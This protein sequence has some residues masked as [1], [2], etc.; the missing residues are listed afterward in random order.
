MPTWL[1]VVLI[2]LVVVIVVR[3]VTIQRKL[4][5]Q[6]P[7]IEALTQAGPIDIELRM[8]MDYITNN[9]MIEENELQEA[10]QYSA[11]LRDKVKDL[12]QGPVLEGGAIYLRH[13]LRF[14]ELV[15]EFY[16]AAPFNMHQRS[17]ADR[18]HEFMKRQRQ[19]Q[20]RGER[21]V[22]AN[23]TRSFVN[24]LFRGVADVRDV[25]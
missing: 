2:L 18:F 11:V 5:S 3:W 17:D 12:L 13:Y 14:A 21:L 25:P 22:R 24:L 16:Q 1:I 7:N 6:S 20:E 23:P 10:I 15:R 4:R 9:P 19:I 8:L